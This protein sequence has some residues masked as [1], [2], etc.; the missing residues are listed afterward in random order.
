MTL[1]ARFLLNRGIFLSE[2]C[3]TPRLAITASEVCDDIDREAIRKAYGIPVVN[4]YGAAE[5]DLVAIEDADGNW[6]INNKTLLV[7]LL[8]EVDDRDFLTDKTKVTYQIL[9][10][11]MAGPSTSQEPFRARMLEFFGLKE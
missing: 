9:E 3:P 5:L 10:R 11:L 2:I 8:D 1:Y 6:V 4:E 7:G